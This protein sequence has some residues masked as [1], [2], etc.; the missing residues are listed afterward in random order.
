MHCYCHART[1][2]TEKDFVVFY[3]KS[4]IS[5]VISKKPPL[6]VSSYIIIHNML[7]NNNIE[8]LDSA[9]TNILELSDKVFSSPKLNK[10]S[11]GNEQMNANHWAKLIKQ[12]SE[13]PQIKH[14]HL[15]CF[16][17]FPADIGLLKQ[18][19]SLELSSA[20]RYTYQSTNTN[21][22][23]S[24]DDFSKEL[25]KLPHLQELIID[26]RLSTTENISSLA[27]DA[28]GDI[29][30][31]QTLKIKMNEME[32]YH[33]GKLKN[34][35]KLELCTSSTKLSE[36]I[37]EMTS[38]EELHLQD[39]RLTHLHLSKQL[40][41]LNTITFNFSWKNN[42]Q[43]FL[44]ISDDFFRLLPQIKRLELNGLPKSGNTKVLTDLHEIFRQLPL[45]Q[46]III[47]NDNADFSM[48]TKATLIADVIT[49]NNV[50]KYATEDLLDILH[51][52]K[53]QIDNLTWVILEKRL[54]KEVLVELENVK[55]YF[56]LGK[57]ARNVDLS[58]ILTTLGWQVVKNSEQADCIVVSRDCKADASK[59][60]DAKK[61]ISDTYLFAWAEKKTG[62]ERFDE[63]MNSNLALLLR[64][65]ELVN[66]TLALDL[67][68]NNYTSNTEVDTCL[69]AIALFATDKDLKEKTRKFIE[70]NLSSDLLTEYKKHNKRGHKQD[71]YE[72]I[73][74]LPQIDALSFAE[75]SFL[76]VKS[77]H[78]WE[79]FGFQDIIQLGGEVMPLAIKALQY[80]YNSIEIP[81]DIIKIH[82]DFVRCF[83]AE[84]VEIVCHNPIPDVQKI[85]FS[86][87]TIK[88][89]HFDYL[90]ED[91]LHEDIGNMKCLKKI[92]FNI[93]NLQNFP[94]TLSKLTQIKSVEFYNEEITTL[95]EVFSSWTRLENLKIFAKNFTSLPD[96]ITNF[97]HITN[98]EL[99]YMDNLVVIDQVFELPNLEYLEV[100]AKNIALNLPHKT[101]ENLKDITIEILSRNFR[102]VK[103]EEGNTLT[104]NQIAFDLLEKII[105]ICP[106]DLD[107]F[108]FSSPYLDKISDKLSKFTELRELS[109]TGIFE[110]IPAC[111]ADIPLEVLCLKSDDFKELP[112]FLATMFTLETMQLS[113][114]FKNKKKKLAQIM[115]YVNIWF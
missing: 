94:K 15:A 34:I 51:I 43:S 17:D 7:K 41:N 101:L 95:P 71:T 86:L 18:L 31:L 50:D 54:E 36:G 39:V 11:F 107:K 2:T 32:L 81:S 52:K 3:D 59:Y 88:E 89:I 100:R 69:L 99:L 74:Q 5:F 70:K 96:W 4:V 10:I 65:E 8:F 29:K 62:V 38:L 105:D 85:L 72:V 26:F 9:Y 93:A 6:F 45:E 19:V 91:Y 25:S 56:L 106:S 67:L 57:S 13:N 55:T 63:G 35:K 46:D 79:K 66:Q 114:H 22:G 98:I 47:K 112:D 76:A 33:W 64:S 103:K 110:E 97:K 87:T 48:T 109:L 90:N 16:P 61:A 75:V 23:L 104:D 108:T 1:S 115:P 20:N 58:K 14:L 53:A 40:I 113:R 73:K 102:D 84:Y 37:N 92:V 82:P 68:T 42:L 80:N 60:F 77:K 28:I 44:N 12:I 83:P 78:H 27:F 24:F 30:S 21:K 111:I 49:K